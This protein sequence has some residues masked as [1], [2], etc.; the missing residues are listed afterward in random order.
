M[1]A[2]SSGDFV[3]KLVLVRMFIAGF[4][5]Y[6]ERVGNDL[7]D[8]GDIGEREAYDN[9][10]EDRDPLVRPADVASLGRFADGEFA[11]TSLR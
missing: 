6:V 9:E 2:V 7:L 11:N 8:G 3:R 4:D 5:F 10:G 1:E